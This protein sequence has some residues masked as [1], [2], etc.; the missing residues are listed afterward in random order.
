MGNSSPLVVIEKVEYITNNHVDTADI[1]FML[2][3]ILRAVKQDTAAE[4]ALIRENDELRQQLEGLLS[5]DVLAPEVQE[6][7]NAIF[8][9]IKQTSEALAKG[10]SENQPTS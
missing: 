4:Q 3:R 6:K 9:K 1:I 7:V 2:R 10:I 5:G 8:V